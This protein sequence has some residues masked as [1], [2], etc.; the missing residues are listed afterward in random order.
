MYTSA[1]SSSDNPKGI[2]FLGIILVSSTVARLRVSSVGA[3]ILAATTELCSGIYLQDVIVF[4]GTID[5][6]LGE[7][8]R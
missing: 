8:D 5:L 2:N 6:V 1:A 4:L 3:A 7:V